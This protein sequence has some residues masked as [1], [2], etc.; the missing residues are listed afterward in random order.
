MIRT[1]RSDGLICLMFLN[2]TFHPSF[3]LEIEAEASQS[4]ALWSEIGNSVIVR[5]L[6]VIPVEQTRLRMWP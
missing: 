1:A 3:V 5:L 2:V 4:T 6:R